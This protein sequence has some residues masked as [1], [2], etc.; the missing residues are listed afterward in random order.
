MPMIQYEIEYEVE[1]KRG[2]GW[3]IISPRPTASLNQAIRFAKTL[4]PLYSSE[5]IRIVKN[6]QSREVME[7]DLV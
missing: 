7:I 5:E 3:I 6:T 4:V 2:N 1:R